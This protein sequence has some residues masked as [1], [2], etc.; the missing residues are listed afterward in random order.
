[1][2]VLQIFKTFDIVADL[3]PLFDFSVIGKNAVDEVK[4]IDFFSFKKIIKHSKK[5]RSL[6]GI[7]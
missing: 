6:T 5:M 2:K 3:I 4:I 7:N 1:M